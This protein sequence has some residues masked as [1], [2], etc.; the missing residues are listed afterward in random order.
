[1]QE[2]SKITSPRTLEDKEHDEL[3]QVIQHTTSVLR[4]PH[5]FLSRVW[6]IRVLG[7]WRGHLI[8]GLE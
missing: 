4:G 5:T 1:M 8:S 6:F 3:A 2:K 7:V